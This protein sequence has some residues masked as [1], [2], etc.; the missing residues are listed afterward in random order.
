MVLE[1][2]WSSVVTELLVVGQAITAKVMKAVAGPSVV[3]QAMAAEVTEAV[4][5]MAGTAIAARMMK[6]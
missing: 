2:T 5:V 6:I 1:W 3:V 4:T